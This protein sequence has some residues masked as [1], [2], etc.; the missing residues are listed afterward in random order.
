ME[1]A[2]LNNAYLFSLLIILFE[3]EEPPDFSTNLILGS[4]SVNYRQKNFKQKRSKTAQ[5]TEFCLSL[6]LDIHLTFCIVNE[7]LTD[8]N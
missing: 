2:L 5:F 1:R 3:L 8:E 4:S 7:T 6:S